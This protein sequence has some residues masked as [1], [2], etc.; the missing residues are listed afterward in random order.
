[1]NPAILLLAVLTAAPS[2]RGPVN[3][4][5]EADEQQ[6]LMRNG[7]QTIVL[8]GSVLVTADGTTLTAP[9]AVYEVEDRRIA[10]SGGANVRS[11]MPV[12]R[13]R[14]LR[15]LPESVRVAIAGT[16]ATYDF[17]NATGF[18]KN[19]KAQVQTLIFTGS[20]IEAERG[21]YVVNDAVL[22]GCDREPPDYALRAK[23]IEVVPGDKAVAHDARFTIGHTT[24]LHVSRFSVSLKQRQARAH[25]PIPR[26][27]RSQLSGYYIGWPIPVPLPGDAELTVEPQMTS[28]AGPRAFLT[29][30]R[31]T[32]FT[33]FARLFW[34]EEVVGRRP[35]RVLVSREPEAGFLL[36]QGGLGGALSTLTGEVSYGRFREHTTGVSASRLN[37]QMALGEPAQAVFRKWTTAVV[38]GLRL[39]HYSTGGTYRDLSLDLSAARQIGPKDSLRVGFVK[40]FLW[41]RTPFVFDQAY[42]PV[43]LNETLLLYRGR[44]SFELSTRYDVEN[45]QLFDVR[46]GVGK[47][48]HCIE[49]RIV[50]HG[51]LSEIS[52]ELHLVGLTQAVQASPDVAGYQQ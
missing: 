8:R 21:K 33:P 9:E 10:L 37:L 38:P 17:R 30:R 7:K 52:L 45:R 51:R 15:G 11:D 42:L 13:R 48:I 29:A 43:E 27:G 20:S 44:Y 12:P 2:F 28:R 1:V 18:V 35:K 34:K 50:W 31:D 25:L 22:T 19:A 40:H 46:V 24:L 3:V 32:L 36:E 6:A 5:V 41:G 26:P 23:R 16:E 49:P 39:A 14:R 4:H 47:V